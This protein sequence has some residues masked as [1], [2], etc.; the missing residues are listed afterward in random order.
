MCL[1]ERGREGGDWG[2][3]SGEILY[4]FIVI[5]GMYECALNEFRILRR[6]MRIYLLLM[7]IRL[8]SLFKE[9]PEER[10]KEDRNSNHKRCQ[11]NPSTFRMASTVTI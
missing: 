1:C 5:W 11:D 8:S 3:E 10:R 4:F 7:E 2:R 6:W 9:P